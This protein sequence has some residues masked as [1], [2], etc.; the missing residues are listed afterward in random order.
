MQGENINNISVKVVEN[1][2]KY[3]IL[4]TKW[5]CWAGIDFLVPPWFHKAGGDVVA[6]V[7][8]PVGLKDN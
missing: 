7:Q 3:P 5:I 1:K 6:V 8:L 4:L 2:H